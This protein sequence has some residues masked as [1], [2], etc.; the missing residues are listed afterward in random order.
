[1]QPTTVN[2]T[3][4]DNMQPTTVNNFTVLEGGLSVNEILRKSRAAAARR[5]RVK[6]VC[7][8]TFIITFIVVFTI[9]VFSSIVRAGQNADND[10]SVKGYTYITVSSNDTLW[11]IACKYSDDH[12]SSVYEY[13]RE[14]KQING[15][16]GDSIYSGSKIIIPVYVTVKH[17]DDTYLVP[18]R[19]T[20]N[21]H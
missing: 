4:G 14:V 15:I 13:I 2:N 8:I 16:T 9:I 18:D 17:T 19:I 1:M 7:I 11:S 12:Y 5:R 20:Y 10:N 21:T 6:R 3:G